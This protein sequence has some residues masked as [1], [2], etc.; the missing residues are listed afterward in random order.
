MIENKC[1]ARKKLN[2]DWIDGYHV[3]DGRH[4][5]VQ[6]FRAIVRGTTELVDVHEVYEDSIR[7]FTGKKDKK[8]ID[9]IEGDVISQF[10]YIKYV[11]RYGDYAGKVG[12]GYYYGLGFYLE[13]V[14]DPLHRVPFSCI[15]CDQE[16]YEVIG[17]VFDNP[18]LL[19]MEDA[20]EE[21]D[22]N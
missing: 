21:K 17:N 11:V 22:S 8:G 20:N 2:G 15:S 6:S 7:R 13:R 1:R 16:E 9:I 19:K 3:K 4:F 5:I 14:G 12:L 18:D 10:D